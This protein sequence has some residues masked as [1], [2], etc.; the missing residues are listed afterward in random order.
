[1]TSSVYVVNGWLEKHLELIIFYAT[2]RLLAHDVAEL[3]TNCA[4]S[5]TND[6]KAMTGDRVELALTAAHRKRR[7]G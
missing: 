2:I 4:K 6:P 1:M 5:V 3:W 7:S